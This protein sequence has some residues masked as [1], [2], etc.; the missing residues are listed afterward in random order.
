METSYSVLRDFGNMSSATILFVLQ[1][2]LNSRIKG[3]LFAAA[4]G[5]G[6]SAEAGM[7]EVY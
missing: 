1:R 6:L 3:S 7:M 4:M 2:I 5:P